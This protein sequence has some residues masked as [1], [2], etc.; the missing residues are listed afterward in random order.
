MANPTNASPDPWELAKSRFLEDLDPHEKDIFNNATL[1]NI[2]YSTSNTNRD[3]AEKSKTRGVVRKLGPLVSAIESYGGAFDAFAQISPQYLSPIWGSI[4]VLLVVAGSYS[5]FYD[6]IVDTLGRIG[7]ILP[8]FRDYER[9]YDGQKH[10]RLY[11]ALSNAYLDIITLCSEF[12]TSIREQ[13]NSKVRRL[14]KPLAFDKQF[15]EAI[16]RFRRHRQNVVDEAET[17]HMIEAAEQ[18][19]AQLVLFAEER[20]RKL[21]ERLSKVDCKC[22]HRKLKES[23]HEGTGAWFTSSP[24]FEQWMKASYSSVLCCYGIPGCGKSV[25]VSSVIDSFDVT[26]TVVVYYCD[27][28]D[29]RTL[30]PSNVF[31][32]LARQALEQIEILPETLALEIEQVEHDGEKLANSQAALI[33]LQKSLELVPGPIFVVL[34]GLD[35]ATEPSQ[36]LIC[37]N[38]KQLIE[39]SGVSVKLFITGR[40]ELGSLLM[41]DSNVP[42][43]R[44]P[45]SSTAISLDI[46]NYVRSST[47]RRIADGLLVIT[48]PDLAQLIVDEL[49]KGAK[50][51]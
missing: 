9:I 15:D 30:E 45:I 8:R 35:E 33:I 25:L 4:R 36:L 42:F 2:Y 41:L 23:R 24:E 21:L 20:R 50:G 48:D 7:D 3:D 13:K 28:S 49:V 39:K 14:L 31:A 47:R 38:L 26:G 51:M 19:D 44:I 34:D 12:R 46:E 37:N 11:Q 10:R 6:K 32:T 22:R 40:D 5:K 1:E 18:R 17:C 27:Y 43:S 29:K 16:E